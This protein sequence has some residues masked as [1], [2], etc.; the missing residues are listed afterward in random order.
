MKN[1]VEIKAQK[2]YKWDLYKNKVFCFTS[3]GAKMG[4]ANSFRLIKNTLKGDPK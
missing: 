2:I 4:K 3:S 1:E